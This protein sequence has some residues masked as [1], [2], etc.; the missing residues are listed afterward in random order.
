MVTFQG[1]SVVRLVLRLAKQAITFR[2]SEIINIIREG[3]RV[4]DVG[5]VES[6]HI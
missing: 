3:V 2:D 5:S 4:K 6:F 1:A